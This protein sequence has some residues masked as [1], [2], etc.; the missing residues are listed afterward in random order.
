MTMQPTMWAR[1]RS[2]T[3]PFISTSVNRV[4]RSAYAMPT[5]SGKKTSKEAT[6]RREEKEGGG[7]GV[8]Q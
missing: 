3:T 8:R 4:G 1:V 6:C 7:G 5:T 2:L